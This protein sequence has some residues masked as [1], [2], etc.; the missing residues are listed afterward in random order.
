MP[1][2]TSNQKHYTLGINVPD[3]FHGDEIT[4]QLAHIARVGFD[5]FFT[6]WEHGYVEKWANA[7]ARHGLFYQSIHAPYLEAGK[8]WQ[9]GEEGE[10]VLCE[11][12]ACLGDCARFDI[13]IMVAHAFMDFVDVPPTEIGFARHARVLEEADRL[14]VTLALEN[15]V[16]S[17]SL[18]ALME[19][20]RGVECCRFCYDAGHES[21]F[22]EGEDMLSLYGDRLC[23]THLNDNFGVTDRTLPPH[24]MPNHDLH[25]AMGDGTIDFADVMDRLDKTPYEGLLCCEIK[26]KNV[27]GRHDHDRYIEMPIEEFY[28]FVLERARA[29]RDRTLPRKNA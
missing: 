16:R 7:A 17:S 14:G 4:E 29:M 24:L 5:G 8:L 1:Q 28:A 13:P 25:L 11:L 20:F 12:L 27:P 6:L 3:R 19:R 23:H 10:R 26:L 18:A 15:L 22:N 9:E 2:R 21:C